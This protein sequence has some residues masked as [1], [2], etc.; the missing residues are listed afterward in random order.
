MIYIILFYVCKAHYYFLFFK[1][2]FFMKLINSI[3]LLAA[4]TFIITTNSQAEDRSGKDNPR[5]SAKIATGDD[6]PKH[7]LNEASR[8]QSEFKRAHAEGV[9]SSVKNKAQ[10][11]A[12][13]PSVV[14]A[15]VVVGGSHGD[16][17]AICKTSA[18]WSNPAFVDLNAASLGVQVG[19][20]SSDLILYLTSTKAAEALKKG[21][22]EL[23]A[24]A[25]VTAGNFD[26]SYTAEGTDIVA[27]QNSSGAYVGASI[28]GGHMS[29][30][31]DSNRAF[32]GKAVE[33]N[34]ILNGR[35]DTTN[36]AAESLITQFTK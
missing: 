13:I 11:I 16:G 36:P 4:F 23:G 24:D 31:D 1:K 12:I 19:A 6:M 3:S 17:V 5:A 8:A 25:S 29:S 2:G 21:K 7:I 28:A 14:T 26:R 20:K 35:V 33:A 27:Y 32:Y 34:E 10:C 22:M 15:A 30:D 9:P 18:G